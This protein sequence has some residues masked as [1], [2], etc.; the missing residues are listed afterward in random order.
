M[1]ERP[2]LGVCQRG[3]RLADSNGGRH[4]DTRHPI[5]Y[6]ASNLCLGPLRGQSSGLKPSANDGPVP[7][8]RSLD[9]APSAVARAAL[10][11]HAPML[12]DRRNMRVASFTNVAETASGCLTSM[13]PL[14]HLYQLWSDR[15]W[16][17]NGIS[18]PRAGWLS[19]GVNPRSPGGVAEGEGFRPALSRLRL[20]EAVR[21][22]IRR[23]C[24]SARRYC[25]GSL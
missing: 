19:D 16:T 15:T 17:F 4:A 8:H 5:Q 1:H 6:V 22:A 21:S 14:P 18:A 9:Q 24:S 13:F 25:S 2:G 20:N 7:I 3:W 12:F 23:R 10:P 11:A